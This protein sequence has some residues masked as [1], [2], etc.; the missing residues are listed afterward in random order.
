MKN[1][2]IGV[3]INLRFF[4]EKKRSGVEEYTINLLENLIK[5]KPQWYFILFFN[6]WKKKLP[7]FKWL[8]M[9]NVEVKEVNFY[10]KILTFSSFVF[11]YP[12]LD[13][14]LNGVDL[15]FLPNFAIFSFS[16]KLPLVL[17]VH[18]FSFFY[19]KEFFTFKSY[20]WHKFCVNYLIKRADKIITVSQS[21]KD[22]LLNF[23]PKI[24]SKKIET[25]YHGISE[26]F[27]IL[28]KNNLKLREIK[29]KYNL[30]DNFIFYLGIVEPRK[31]IN[32]VIKAFNFLKK[33]FNK[34]IKD[35]KLVIA[36]QF[37]WR[38]KKILDLIE[39]SL[40][41][42]DI[43]LINDFDCRERVYFYNLA[44]IF[45]YPSFFEG[46]GLPVLEAMACG[47]PVITS[48]ISSLP[49]ITGDAA[50]LIDPYNTNDLVLAF[51][52][53]I[54]DK[55]LET[56]LINKGLERA[57]NFSWKRCAEQ[58]SKVFEDLLK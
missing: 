28:D 11:K 3:N 50:I 19:F 15:F 36:G 38:Y 20:L 52:N 30:P 40:F 49:E 48:N 39:K 33:E 22:D 57:K 2:K 5:I 31:N 42:K 44:K 17:T 13:K 8:K 9:K 1:L 27:K 10:P 56:Y 34:E 24:N 6:K 45:V 55:D 35:F 54:L 53:L 12:K 18:D 21:T 37:G 16:K 4:S 14:L 58:T 23:F 7:S 26:E 29:E 32:L 41:K 51:K 47:L 43:F 25:I 46:F